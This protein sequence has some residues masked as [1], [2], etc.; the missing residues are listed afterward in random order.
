MHINVHK[1]KRIYTL[2]VENL[3]LSQKGYHKQKIFLMDFPVP[4]DHK[5]KLST[6]TPQ[7]TEEIVQHEG[8]AH[9]CR[10]S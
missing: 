4:G 8:C 3:Y 10:V 7:G 9:C 5:I 1:Y 2:S 6:W